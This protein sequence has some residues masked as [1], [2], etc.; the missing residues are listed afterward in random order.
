LTLLALTLLALLLRGRW[1][2]LTFLLC[3][4]RR[5][6]R[7]LGS[8]WRRFALLALLRR[9]WRRRRRGLTLLR[10]RRCRR[11]WAARALRGRWRGA[12]A[13]LLRTGFLA[14]RI[15]LL[16]ALALSPGIGGRSLGN[17]QRPIGLRCA[18]GSWQP[19]RNRRQH[20]TGKEDMLCSDHSAYPWAVFPSVDCIFS[21]SKRLSP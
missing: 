1:Y 9:W 6:C 12:A 2:A 5:R 14:A 15:L 17:D 4:R 11:R 16:I 7:A 10:R 13:R 20:G 21:R 18:G 19:Q 8:R 3:R